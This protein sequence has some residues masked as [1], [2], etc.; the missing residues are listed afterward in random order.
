M[1]LLG[2][3]LVSLL[4]AGVV[5]A[6]GLRGAW[7]KTMYFSIY[8]MEDM[9]A[10]DGVDGTG[11]NYQIAPN[12]GGGVGGARKGLLDKSR[13]CSLLQ[14]LDHIWRTTS[15]NRDILDEGGN[16]VRTEK[17]Y[18][19]KPDIDTVKFGSSGTPTTGSNLTPDQ[20]QTYTLD[21]KNADGKIIYK[22][23]VPIVTSDGE[24]FSVKQHGYTGNVDEP[25]RLW[26]NAVPPL[27]G[28]VDGY[29]VSLPK[30]ADRAQE[31]LQIWEAAKAD[32][33]LHVG[34]DEKD[35]PDYDKHKEADDQVKKHLEY[36][37]LA[38]K[39]TALFRESDLHKNLKA[40]GKWRE[41]FGVAPKWDYHNSGD[42]Q[43]K[44]WPVMNEKKTIQKIMEA[45]V[46]DEA[47]AKKIYD[48]KWK[49]IKSGEGYRGTPDLRTTLRY[50]CVRVHSHTTNTIF[51]SVCSSPIPMAETMKW[52][53]KTGCNA[54]IDAAL[55]QSASVSA[56]PVAST[57]AANSKPKPVATVGGNGDN[58]IVTDTI[59]A[60]TLQLAAKRGHIETFSYL[61]SLGARLDE[62][63]TSLSSIRSLVWLVTQ[64]PDASALLRLFFASPNHLDQ[65]G[66]EMLNE[67]LFG[68]LQGCAAPRSSKAPSIEEYL[69]FARILLDA[70]AN[71]NAF[72]ALGSSSSSVLSAAVR[73]LSPDLVR[74]LLHCGACSNG[75][76][77]APQ[78]LPPVPRWPLHVP[79]CAIAYSFATLSSSV[80]SS[81]LNLSFTQSSL[82]EIV[83]VLLHVGHANVNTSA[84]YL[85]LDGWC[86]SF[87]NPLFVFLDA[88][89]NWDSSDALSALKFILE[90]G[91]SP[92]IRTTTHPSSDF[93][94]AGTVSP[95][96]LRHGRYHLGPAREFP[97]IDLLDR[98]GVGKLSSPTFTEV[99]EVLARDHIQPSGDENS[100][101]ARSIADEL[102]RYDY[103]ASKAPL[104]CEVDDSILCAWRRVITSLISPLLATPHVL[105][106]FLHAY[107][108][109]K[110]TCPD[111]RPLVSI[112]YHSSQNHVIGDDLAHITVQVLVDAGADVNHRRRGDGA[113]EDG[114]TVLHV[115]CLW[116]AGR[117]P[118][119]DDPLFGWK[120]SCLGF[121][122]TASRAKFIEFLVETCGADASLRHRGLN[123]GQILGQL[124]RPEL[125]TEEETG[126]S[127]SR[128]RRDTSVVREAREAMENLLGKKR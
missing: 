9:L 2:T 47:K 76:P 24:P 38:A 4:W 89:N 109:R 77:D 66:Q 98:W 36:G 58:A 44:S 16:V 94:R 59:K 45:S 20:I 60:L 55:H 13:R 11:K 12:C 3:L 116:L 68:L 32:G 23:P 17:Y 81:L 28:G 56:V 127:G 18:D 117:S 99:L 114:P 15:T 111:H 92:S 19:T 10:I 123:P 21:A 105:G 35:H 122:H 29:L 118:E 1:R 104:E 63:G 78:R 90:C 84:P 7:E 126:E 120:P 30:I 95:A 22:T 128:W 107:I 85:H 125:D 65:L 5:S 97:I 93:E 27:P 100:R 73:T 79:L 106:E 88:V 14:F 110:A 39:K 102:A 34:D 62:P 31:L 41:A 91:A 54:A 101:R 72:F 64:G 70:G 6:Y 46:G 80:S 57:V 82:K 124:R 96:L 121:R 40:F 26:P 61:M 37:R 25:G 50:L 69:G 74:L 83:C 43:V 33:T 75:P 119:E 48:N 115:L 42:D 113:S 87:T 67:T 71:P 86:I 8:Q 108:I 52:A 103:T 53:C 51:D 49:E 112:A